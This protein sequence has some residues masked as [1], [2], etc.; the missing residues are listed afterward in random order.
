MTVS[1]KLSQA[2]RPVP[3]LHGLSRAARSCRRSWSSPATISMPSRSASG[4]FKFVSYEPRSAIKFERNPDYFQAGKP[5]FD[6]MEYRIITDVTAL[7]N[8]VMS[9]QVNF[10][11]EIPP[12][13]W[14]KVK[15]NAEPGRPDARRL[16]LLLA[17]R[18]HHEKAA[19]QSQGAPGHRPSAR[20]ARPWCWAAFF[21]N[22]T[23]ILGGVIPEWNW[24]Y[25]DIDYLQ[26]RGR[27]RGRPRSCWPRPAI[28]TASRRR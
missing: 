8:A 3:H 28:P 5:Y 9:G 4:P 11:N 13:D 23:P 22:A 24:G 17:A 20:T 12:K 16:A 25:A 19:R 7:T 26:A 1:F 27:C 18:Q 21:G 2:H 14:A 6:A 10:C 15:S